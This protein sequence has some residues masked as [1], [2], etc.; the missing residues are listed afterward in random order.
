[1]EGPAYS[2]F[3]METFSLNVGYIWRTLADLLVMPV[4]NQ[5]TT[6]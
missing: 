3:G 1:M 6:A 2:R 4:P 5:E